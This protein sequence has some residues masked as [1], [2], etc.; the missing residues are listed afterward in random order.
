MGLV[1]FRPLKQM[2]VCV[3]LSLSMYSKTKNKKNTQTFL[4]K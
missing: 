4:Q 2:W 3:D 1:L